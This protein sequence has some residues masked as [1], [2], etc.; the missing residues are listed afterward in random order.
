MEPIIELPVRPTPADLEAA[1]AQ[2][3]MRK[4]ELLHGAYYRGHCR[5]ATIAR[6][7]SIKEQFVHHQMEFGH[8]IVERIRHPADEQ[9]YDVFIPVACGEP[10]PE[11]VIE[12]EHLLK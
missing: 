11:Q 10:L 3:M 5:N 1:Y 4:E 6:W 8:K 9:V 2:G 12:D 7:S